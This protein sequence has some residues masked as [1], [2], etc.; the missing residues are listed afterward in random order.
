LSDEFKQISF[1][2]GIFTSKGGKHVDYIVQQITKKMVAY[3]LKKK[4]IEVKPSI[5]KEQ[6]T[7]FL[8]STIVN[9]SFD[10]QTKDYLNTP[11]S[12]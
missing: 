6:I 10:S 7:V 4:K 3:I 8:N 2:N 12:K 1:V 5:I 11:S 9:P